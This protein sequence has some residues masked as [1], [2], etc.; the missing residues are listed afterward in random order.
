[1]QIPKV[2]TYEILL[3]QA[4]AYAGFSFGGGARFTPVYTY[5]VKNFDDGFLMKFFPLPGP[6]INF[7]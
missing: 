4:T 6:K 2:R 3:T 5:T 1:M 7:P